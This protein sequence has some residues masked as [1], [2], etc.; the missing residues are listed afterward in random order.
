MKNDLEMYQSVLS[1]RNEHRKK[2]EKQLRI[3]KRTLPV[4]ACFCLTLGLW[5]AFRERTEKL[6]EIP[7][8]PGIIE[9]TTT[10]TA[11]ISSTAV[12]ISTSAATAASALKTTLTASTVTGQTTKT[13][14]AVTETPAVTQTEQTT[15]QQTE[16]PI[17]STNATVTSAVT[18]TA[19]DS[20]S[21]T[22]TFGDMS[23]NP[24]PPDK[25]IYP[26]LF[27]D[28]EAAVNAVLN[29]D[30]VLAYDDA[31]AS[32]VYSG[33]FGRFRDEG[34]IYRVLENKNIEILDGNG[35]LLH[36]STQRE[37]IGVSY[38]VKYKDNNY[39]V[40][41]FSVDQNISGKTKGIAEYLKERTGREETMSM[42]M[43]GQYITIYTTDQ[44]QWF[45]SAFIDSGHYFDISTLATV[46]DFLSF[47]TEF[48][49]EKIDLEQ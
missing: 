21:V 26:L 6:P 7:D 43:N 14:A 16:T 42:S 47:L 40:R 44:R 36:P 37:D 9:T 39:R 17:S 34:F 27:D 25:P 20:C 13:T 19:N 31:E 1:K 5:A 48:S 49:Y 30:M 38:L 12:N 46:E 22:T 33:M 41:F 32:A 45:M 24:I 35:I 23:I 10:V 28:M 29:P 15:A 8:T 18:S 11:V 2:K 4:L 3:I